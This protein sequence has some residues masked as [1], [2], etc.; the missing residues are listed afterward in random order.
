MVLVKPQSLL[1]DD[2]IIRHAT[3]FGEIDGL[4]RGFLRIVETPKFGTGHAQRIEHGRLSSAGE[5]VGL[6]RQ[7]KSG[8]TVANFWIFI[9]GQ[10]LGQV[11]QDMEIIRRD[12]R[13]FGYSR[14]KRFDCVQVVIALIVT[15][16]G[17]P[18]A[19]EVLSGNTSDKT[20][21]KN[22]LK[23]IEEQYGK[24]QRIWVMDRGVPTEEVLAQMRASDPPVRYLVGTPKGRL[25]QYEQKLL[26]QPWPEVRA[27]VSVKLL[28]Q[29]QE[30]YVLARSHDR[31]NKERAMRRR[32]LKGLWKRLRQLQ[33]MKLKRDAL[34]EKVGAAK[35]QYPAGA[36]LVEI[37]VAEPEAKLVFT[38]RKD[39]LRQVRRREG[40]YLL[41]TN[42]TGYEPARLWEF[43]LQLAQVEEA[44]RNFKGDLSLRPVYHQ[45]EDRIEAHI[46]VA[47]LAYCLH[48]TLR[49]MLRPHAPGLTPR[50]A[51]EKFKAVT[52]IDV[53]LP[54]SDGRTII[55]PRHTQPEA[56]LQLLLHA[57]KLKLPPQ[58]P[59]RLSACGKLVRD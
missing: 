32:Q 57:M 58:P 40:R 50:A 3:G 7:G 12:K 30:V 49:A 34:M 45:R 14:D 1:N 17:F 26:E 33:G 37:T 56:D 42:L 54:T 25:S 43:Y 27:G 28:A 16:E 6:G 19:Y 10:H 9:R 11:D 5:G 53:H 2:R 29:E 38:L 55:L 41:R 21:L 59:P 31:M 48:V 36:R 24:A 20:T 51:L 22:F 23:K 39:K 13:R 47:F 52:M 35:Q 8:M 18:L 4:L 46:F 15:P 44:F